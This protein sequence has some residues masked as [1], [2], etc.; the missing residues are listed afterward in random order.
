MVTYFITRK[1]LAE[2]LHVDVKTLRSWIKRKNIILEQGLIPVLKVQEIKEKFKLCPP[3][4]EKNSE[5]DAESN[6]IQ[7]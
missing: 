1:E 5:G 6:N 7:N 4:P 2:E 3:D